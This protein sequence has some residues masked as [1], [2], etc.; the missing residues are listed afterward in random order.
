MLKTLRLPAKI[1]V[2]LVRKGLESLKIVSKIVARTASLT[3]VLLKT[4]FF[5]FGKSFGA[6]WSTS[7]A[8]WDTF[9]VLRSSKESPQIK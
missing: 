8:F 7:G 3:N 1:K 6:S 2:F 4:M 5:Q 9:G